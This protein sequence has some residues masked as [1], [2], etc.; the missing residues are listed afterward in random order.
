MPG[1]ERYVRERT[2]TAPAGPVVGRVSGPSPS[3]PK[4]PNSDVS[5]PSAGRSWAVR[6]LY[7]IRLAADPINTRVTALD[8]LLMSAPSARAGAGRPPRTRPTYAPGAG[9][10]TAGPAGRCAV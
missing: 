2:G 5:V 8:A 4:S 3:G 6:A 9:G 7:P 10:A 1:D